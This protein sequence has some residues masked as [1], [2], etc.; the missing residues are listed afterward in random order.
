MRNLLYIVMFICTPIGGPNGNRFS[1]NGKPDTGKLS[2]GRDVDALPTGTSRPVGNFGRTVSQGVKDLFY[3]RSKLHSV[4]NQ[5][6]QRI[7]I[8]LRGPGRAGATKWRWCGNLQ[9]E[10]IFYPSSSRAIANKIPKQ[11]YTALI[12]EN[13]TYPT[14]NGFFLLKTG[15]GVFLNYSDWLYSGSLCGAFRGISYGVVGLGAGSSG[16]TRRYH[17]KNTGNDIGG[18]D[19]WFL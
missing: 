5:L 2:T 1:F 4:R 17:V 3:V 12:M 8:S 10:F 11:A 13:M 7:A 16:D 9:L 15:L 18:S 6:F 14:G 19:T